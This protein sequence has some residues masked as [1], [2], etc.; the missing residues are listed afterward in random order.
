MTKYIVVIGGVI[1]GVGKGVATAAIA[2]I[3]KEYGYSVT[4]IKIDPYINCD[5]GTLRPTEHG[6]VWVTEDG[7]EIDQDLGNYERFLSQSI[8][9]MN[10][11]T[12][13]QI[14]RDLIEK[15]I[16]KENI[17]YI[18]VTYLPIP[19]HIEEM[20]TKP[21]QIAIKLLRESGIQPDFILCR[22]KKALDSIRKRKIE[23]YANIISDHIISMPDVTGKN[24]ANTIY[25]VPLD[26]E[27]ERLGEKL[28]RELKLEK[29]KEPNWE[30]WEKAV[31]KIVS[32]SK[33][34]RIAMV[35]KYLDI[36]DFQLKDS[37]ISINEALKH[38][39]AKNDVKV[40][41]EWIDSKEFENNLDI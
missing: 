27:K 9:K 32:P 26:L 17:S 35:G 12:T 40:E 25:V 14:Y 22:G 33:I 24:T 10:N 37:Y 5:A 21:T 41:I 30:E 8:P 3:I 29:R 13:G 20:K 1:S 16:G 2:R 4:A 19:S 18:L 6:E 11:I 23:K 31:K 36:G 28:L 39:G 38:A 7:G 34:L 15:E